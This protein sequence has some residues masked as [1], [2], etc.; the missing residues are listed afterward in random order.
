VADPTLSGLSELERRLIQPGSPYEL[1]L[2]EVDGIEYR[3]YARGPET[4]PDI[5]R[6]ALA[7]GDATLAISVERRLSYRDA[8]ALAGYLGSRLRSDF[9]MGPG[10]RIGIAIHDPCDW[11]VAFLAVTS[12][13]GT[14]V[15]LKRIEPQNITQCLDIA[16]CALLIVDSPT[17]RSFEH[18]IRGV[19]TVVVRSEQG[20]FLAASESSWFHTVL[21]RTSDANETSA[22]FAHVSSSQDALLTFTSGTTGPPK[23]VI[24]THGAVISGMMNMIFS[25]TLAAAGQR[26]V[27]VRGQRRRRGPCTLVLSPL[28][29]VSGYAQLLL[30]L[31]VGGKLAFVPRWECSQVIRIID[32]ESVRS[33]SGATIPQIKELL[34]EKDDPG[35]LAGVSVAGVE[36]PRGVLEEISAKWPLVIV[37][38]GYGLTETNGSVSAISGAALRDHPFSMGRVVPTLDIRVIG[39]GG[40]V[41]L[42]G[43]L[44]EIWIRGSSMM[45]GYICSSAVPNGLIDGW[46]KTGDIGT[47]TADRILSIAERANEIVT[48]EGI[49]IFPTAVER[50]ALSHPSVEEAVVVGVDFGS[51]QK[52]LV[53]AICVKPGQQID[54]GTIDANISA[55]LLLPSG[56]MEIVVMREFPRNPSGKIDRAA[57]RSRLTRVS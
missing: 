9:A 8:F 2:L 53:V 5:Y 7:M 57:L 24:S 40:A 10:S 36:L 32:Q 3:S 26:P 28:Y 19:V 35:P 11:I 18:L 12:L 21:L 33:L 55:E 50:V 56:V 6:R 54:L 30:A 27:D 51:V 48:I 46:F 20:D 42:P 31:F 16:G 47:I 29:H 41:S 22:P 38:T 4:L 17:A 25:A 37:G 52:S 44:G 45:R 15:L 49:E 39:R 13:G 34:H 14:A 43:E 1:R 23:G